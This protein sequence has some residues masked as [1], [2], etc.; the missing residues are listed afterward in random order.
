MVILYGISNCDTVKKAMAWLSRQGLQ[1]TFHD[2][3]KHGVPIDRLEAWAQAVGAEKLVNRQGTTWRKLN[4]DS[5]SSASAWP[6]ARTLMQVNPSL[7]KRPIV[8]WQGSSGPITVGF[9]ADKWLTL[10]QPVAEK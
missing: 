10:A 6:G 9:D 7:I 3:K 8:E 1:Y 5:Q 4:A 2:F